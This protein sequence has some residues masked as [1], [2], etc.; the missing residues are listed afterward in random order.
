MARRLVQAVLLKNGR[1]VSPLPEFREKFVVGM[2]LKEEIVKTCYRGMVPF[3]IGRQIKPG[4]MK[5]FGF[6]PRKP[7]KTAPMRTAVGLRVIVAGVRQCLRRTGS[8]LDLKGC[9]DLN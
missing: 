5:S 3:R 4:P 8:G 9:R 2:Q 6:V 7:L 1:N